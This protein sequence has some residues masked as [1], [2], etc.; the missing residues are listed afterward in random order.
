LRYTEK[1]FSTFV[2]I[3]DMNAIEFDTTIR[4]GLIHVPSQYKEIKNTPARVIVMV[5]ENV[6]KVNYNK[7]K[8]IKLFAEAHKMGLFSKIDNTIKWQKKLRNDWD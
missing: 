6:Q 5:D 1:F 4:K 8:L 3:I 7:T 2:K